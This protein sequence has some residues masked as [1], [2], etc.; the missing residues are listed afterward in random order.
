[1]PLIDLS[2]L[3]NLKQSDGANSGDLFGLKSFKANLTA[4]P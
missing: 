3:K 4:D 1:M 2:L